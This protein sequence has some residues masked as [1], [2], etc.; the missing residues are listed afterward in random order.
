MTYNL[1][2]PADDPGHLWEERRPV[3]AQL[4]ARERPGVLGTQEGHF[5]QIRDIAADLPAEYEWIGEG[6]SGGSEGEF[7]AI[8]YDAT[9][10]T[11]LRYAHLWLSETP[12]LIGSTTW[13][14]GFPRMATW[15]RFS[16][17]DTGSE[18]VVVNTHLD[19]HS[20]PSRF[21]S[22]GLLADLVGSFAGLPVLVTG[23]FNAAAEDSE[24]YQRLVTE[25][26]LSDAWLEA[27]DQR[28]PA[29]ATFAG[30]EPPTVRGA[31]IDWILTTPGVTAEVAAIN[32]FAVDGAFASDH[33]P[34]Q[35]LLRL[36][37]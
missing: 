4:L 27:K 34:V 14:N 20:A 29:Y 24:A 12:Q 17:Q 2:F 13:G 25:T 19:N 6:R 36:P 23:D 18:F 37:G 8:F 28:T 35:V 30:Y 9:R 26:E 33:L 10:L 32:P 31:R 22:A 5:H 21:R 15:V 7:M 3:L 16:D 1:R 11:P